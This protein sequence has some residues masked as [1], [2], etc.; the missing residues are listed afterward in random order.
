M[1]QQTEASPSTGMWAKIKPA[2]PYLLTAGL[3]TLGAY[4][5]YRLLQPVNFKDVMT[6]VRGTPCS[7]IPSVQVRLPVVRCAIAS[8]RRL[9]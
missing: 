2:V 9:G 5:L 8:I 3:F 7:A 4:A 1:T 6:Q